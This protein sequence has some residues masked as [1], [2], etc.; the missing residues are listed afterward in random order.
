MDHHDD[1]KALSRV[2][3]MKEYYALKEQKGQMLRAA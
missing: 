1:W 2:F 3:E